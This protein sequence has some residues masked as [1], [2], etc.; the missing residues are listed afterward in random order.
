MTSGKKLRN[1]SLIL[2]VAGGVLILLG[3]VVVGLWMTRG[4]EEGSLTSDQTKNAFQ[5]WRLKES[6]Q[7]QFI[8]LLAQDYALDGDADGAR[9]AVAGWD[10]DKLSKVFATVEFQTTDTQTLKQ[11]IALRKALGLPT[12]TFA[13]P[14]LFQ[15]DS[16]L[17]IIGLAVVFLLGAG[18]VALWPAKKPK[19]DE[20]AAEAEAA[21]EQAEGAAEE[22][23]DQQTQAALEQ[24]AS[25]AGAEKAEGAAQQEGQ[26]GQGAGGGGA[27][28]PAPGQ[29]GLDQ[30]VPSEPVEA[31]DIFSSLFDDE[32]DELEDLALLARGLEDLEITVLVGTIEDTLDRLYG[33]S[34]R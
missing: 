6:Q 14:S 5:P 20:D 27:G 15:R 19:E 31:Q 16:M 33:M 22:L 34:R 2:G 26:E 7:M 11:L 30:L 28:A 32:D 8:L 18:V 17:W 12:T 24:A 21:E 13:A 23:L 1:V 4:Q 3:I 29:E 9:E 25:E 10:I